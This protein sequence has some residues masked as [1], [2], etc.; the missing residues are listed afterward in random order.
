MKEDIALDDSV[1]VGQLSRARPEDFIK[2]AGDFVIAWT[3]IAFTLPLMVFVALAIKCDSDGP[4]FYRQERIGLGGRRFWL[5]KFRSMV[6]DAERDGRPVWAAEHD[7]R[8]TRVGRY[9]RKVRIDEL[10]QLFNVLRGDMSMVGPRPERP[11]FVDQF[12]RTIPRFAERHNV[13]PGITGWAQINYPYGASIEDARNKLIYDLHYTEN[14]SFLL[15]LR[16]LIST[17]R[18][19]IS[20]QGAR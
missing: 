8:I 18:V 5:F 19:V 9:I 2:R 11:Y 3:L 10:P 14:R 7:P 1:R 16:I 13:R 15:D 17:I 12:S 6:R 20:R 4:V